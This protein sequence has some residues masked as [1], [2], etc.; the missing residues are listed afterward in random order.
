MIYIYQIC[1]RQ[2]TS[3]K[4]NRPIFVVGLKKK[5]FYWIES[6]WMNEAMCMEWNGVDVESLRA[7]WVWFC[8]SGGGGNDEDMNGNENH[9]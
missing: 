4:A 9:H 7:I 8:L 5:I 1:W 2:L 6:E 3:T